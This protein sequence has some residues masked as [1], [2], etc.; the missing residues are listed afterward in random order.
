MSVP[1]TRPALTDRTGARSSPRSAGRR[2]GADPAPGVAPD[3]DFDDRGLGAAPARD[4]RRA[5][6]I[7]AP[8]PVIVPGVVERISRWVEFVSV[9]QLVA[10][11]I[12]VLIVAAG[13]W[14]LVR[15]PEPPVELGLPQSSGAAPAATLPASTAATATTLGPSLVHVVGAVTNPGVYRLDSGDRV[16]DA[17]AAAGGPTPDADLAGINLAAVLRDGQRVYVPRQGEVDPAAVPS[18]V[19]TPAGTQAVGPVNVNSASAAE[20][21]AL[22][23]V[24]P[25]TA[26]A[27]VQDR[28]ENGPFASVDD[29]DRVAGIG[30]AKLAALRDLVTV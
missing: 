11:A 2:V 28:D 24:G 8:R 10:S 30:P 26:A 9:P 29:L 22:P 14:W 21:E 20:L 4:R 17:V 16:N 27:I 23:G 15:A 13:L 7:E 3:G 18:E 25:A 19:A 6:M 5:P 12:A 1:T